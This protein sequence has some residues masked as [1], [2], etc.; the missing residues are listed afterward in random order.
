MDFTDR[1]SQVGIYAEMGESR[2]SPKNKVSEDV[3]DCNAR[4]A[5]P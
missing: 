5:I 1:A 4:A 3:C 2:R